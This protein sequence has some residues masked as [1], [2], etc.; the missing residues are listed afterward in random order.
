MGQY[1]WGRPFVLPQI[2]RGIVSFIADAQSDVHVAISVAGTSSPLYEIVIGGWANTKSVIRNGAQGPELASANVGLARPGGKNPL[3][4]SLDANTG[5]IQVG[6]GSPGQ[7]PILS[8][9]DS[10]FMSV[11]S[12]AFSAWN[13]PIQ[14][15]QIAF[16]PLCAL[17]LAPRNGIYDWSHPFTLPKAGSGIVCFTARAHSDVHV[18]LSPDVG[19]ADGMYEIVIG[20]WKNTR[21]VIRRG[22]QGVEIA[23]APVGLAAPDGDNVLW[24]YTDSSGIIQVGRGVPGAQTSVFLQAM[25]DNAFIGA[26]QHVAFSSWD[27]PITYSG[28]ATRPIF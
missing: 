3:W 13:T 1:D 21:S 6:R 16:S 27:T 15:S 8:Y 2:S 4:V 22:A 9:T 20:G 28:I 17:S 10:N 12:V 7:E 5:L 14:Y 24:V 18:A 19:N 26:A 23:N 25:V 11:Q